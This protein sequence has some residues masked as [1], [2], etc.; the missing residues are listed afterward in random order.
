MSIG[1]SDKSPGDGKKR[2][3]ALTFAALTLCAGL[4]GAGVVFFP[5]NN[6][7]FQAAMT[8]SGNALLGTETFEGSNL[9]PGAVASF[10]DP[11]TQGVA[12]GPYPAGLVQPMTVQSNLSGGA[13]VAP[14]PRPTSGLAA[15]SAGFAGATSDGVVAGSSGDSLDWIFSAATQVAGVGLDTLSFIGASTLEIEVYDLSNVLLGMTTITGDS[16][17]T[18]FLGI[19]ATVG[20]LIGRINFF[21]PG[22]RAEGGDNAML[23]Q[24][25]QVPAPVPEP[26]SLALLAIGLAAFGLSRRRMKA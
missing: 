10:N 16:A 4:V 9:P 14:N 23:F 25:S 21:S 2:W 12:N 1:G 11:L 8:A 19:Q 3:V 22:D 6:A 17:G 24:P 13:A 18:N 15:L 26:A 20:D 5:N 7:G